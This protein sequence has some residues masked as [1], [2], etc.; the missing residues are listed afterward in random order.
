MP[1][2]SL[3]LSVILVLAAPAL[4]AQTI[5]VPRSIG[6][7]PYHP[8]GASVYRL[9]AGGGVNA[10][11]YNVTPVTEIGVLSLRRGTNLFSAAVILNQSTGGIPRR[12]F[13]EYDLLYGYSYELEI[14]RQG[15]RPAF[16]HLTVS[17][18]IGFDTYTIRWRQSRRRTGDLLSSQPN[19]FEYAA[20][21]PV[22]LQAM[23]EPS[24]YVGAGLLAYANFNAISPDFG[25][26][27]GL[28]AR[29]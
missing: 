21:L 5:E 27:I 28:E 6:I 24:K 29:Y 12:T 18:G 11:L 16:Y 23:F 13:S 26:A 17:T 8:Q 1:I 15:A 4:R 19:T 2:R 9:F 14:A 10:G 25:I 20:G 7:D 22:Q 3:I